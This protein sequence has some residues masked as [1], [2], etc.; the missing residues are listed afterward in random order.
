M[1]W[2]VLPF[3]RAGLACAQEIPKASSRSRSDGVA[4]WWA[5]VAEG[6]VGAKSTESHAVLLRGFLSARLLPPHSALRTGKVRSGAPEEENE[7]EEE[8]KEESPPV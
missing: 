4:G 2:R 5:L 1:P 7:G 3:S 8:E 6:G